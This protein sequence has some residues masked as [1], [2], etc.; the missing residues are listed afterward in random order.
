MTRL[1]RYA[2]YFMNRNPKKRG[3]GECVGKIKLV[4]GKYL[5]VELSGYSLGNKNDRAVFRQ[6]IETIENQLRL[7]ESS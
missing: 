7:A 1:A 6:A 5:N 2:V 3:G 4:N